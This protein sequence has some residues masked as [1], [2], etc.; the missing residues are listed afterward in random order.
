MS[1]GGFA[2]LQSCMSSMDYAEPYPAGKPTAMRIEDG[3]ARIFVNGFLLR[4]VPGE[5]RYRG[6]E[7]TSYI[8]IQQQIR[9]AENNPTAKK[10][11]LQIESPGGAIPGL[12][13]TAVSILNCKKPTEAEIWYT[14]HDAAYTLAGVCQRVNANMNSVIG[15]IGVFTTL[16]DSSEVAKKEGVRVICIKSGQ[17][18]GAGIPGVKITDEQIKGIQPIVSGIAANLFGLIS[19]RRKVSRDAL[20][21]KVYSV[22]DALR[23]GLI[24]SIRK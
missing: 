9:D 6:I 7:A 11:I 10:I 21:G 18:K 20:S 24:D 22:N 5:F 19:Q 14:C 1:A 13:E 17:H 4:S 3:T 15:G 12:Y 8:D 23:N 16:N 2:V